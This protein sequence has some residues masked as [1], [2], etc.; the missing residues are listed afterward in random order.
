MRFGWCGTGLLLCAACG[1]V[2]RNGASASILTGGSAGSGATAADTTE[3]TGG[4]G[5]LNASS[6]G[7]D[8][9]GG[10][11]GANSSD[12]AQPSPTDV[13][14]DCDDCEDYSAQGFSYDG[15]VPRLAWA[16]ARLLVLHDAFDAYQV[17]LL[18]L[19]PELFTRWAQ[20]VTSYATTALL[21]DGGQ[22]VV[23][24]SYAEDRLDV[25]AESR[26]FEPVTPEVEGRSTPGRVVDGDLH[27]ATSAMSGDTLYQ[28]GP[29]TGPFDT[30]QR[31]E[32][33]LIIPVQGPLL[34]IARTN[35]AESSTV[36][37]STTVDGGT[38]ELELPWVANIAALV[39]QGELF[40]I[41]Q[42]PLQSANLSWGD[43]ERQLGRPALDAGGCN[44]MTTANYP[45]ICP[46]SSS[47]L[48][49]RS[50]VPL[51]ARLFLDETEQPWLAY[52]L[53]DVSERCSWATVGGCFETLPCNCV[54]QVETTAVSTEL[55]VERATDPDSGL[56]VEL[57]TFTGRL[58]L[59]QI[60]ARAHDGRIS[61]AVADADA[62]HSDVYVL[63]FL[64]PP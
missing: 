62:R 13:S 45:D 31:F 28:R 36:L 53:A 14:I 22:A 25:F 6:V 38:V 12:V 17:D 44:G 4:S 10:S 21:E 42:T 56:R 54:E 3:G 40:A 35:F 11:A 61:V 8:G 26:D 27:L 18:E 63:R 43:N 49:E 55:V 5:G 20:E 58:H 23:V 60:A 52:I 34:P 48:G 59:A 15:W 64:A 9:G 51:A 46:Q 19:T 39:A 33:Y 30:V 57:P 7:G 1:D 24:D 29:L 47:D 50:D 32:S 2:E 41:W 37:L 16:D